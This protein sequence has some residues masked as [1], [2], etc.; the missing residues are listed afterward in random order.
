LRT[1]DA[2]SPLL[3]NFALEYAIQVNQ[4]SLTINGTDGLLVYAVDIS[5][6]DENIGM[7]TIKKNPSF[8]RS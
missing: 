1:G 7:H 5:I 8:T 4:E 3:L 2:L 6:L